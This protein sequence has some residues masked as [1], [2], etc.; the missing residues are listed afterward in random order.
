MKD[1][2]GAAWCTGSG[3]AIRRSA[4]DQIGG[5]PIGSVAEDV[6]CSTLLLGA[7]WKTCFVHEPLQYGTVPDSFSGH[8]KQ[9]ARWVSLHHPYV[10]PYSAPTDHFQTI[11]TVQTSAKLNFFL[12]GQI[13]GK[14]TFLQRF[15]GFVFT[16]GTISTVSATASLLMFPIV[17]VSGFRLVAYADDQQLRWLLRLAFA[18]LIINRMNEW[19]A[20]VPVGYRFAWRG[21]LNTLWMAP[22]QYF[23]LPECPFST[24]RYP[25]TDT[26]VLCRS[27]G[28][29]RPLISSSPVARR[30]ICY[31]LLIRQY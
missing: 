25:R 31:L 16:L 19:V 7:G 29:N 10:R 22:C 27:R 17:L 9:R 14:L 18:S 2:I 26:L 12:F 1:A 6:L 28:C 11:G 3:Y 24:C 20:F 23:L 4:L 13:C 15:C 5:F 30:K 21:N 8:I